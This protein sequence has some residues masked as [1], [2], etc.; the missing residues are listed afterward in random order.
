MSHYRR[1]AGLC[2]PVQ[3]T[4]TVRLILGVTLLRLASETV[5]QTA[6]IPPPIASPSVST[7]F[8]DKGNL[9]GLR[10]DDQLRIGKP[11]PDDQ[12]LTFTASDAI[13]GVVER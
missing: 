10:F 6:V 12:A 1:R 2:A 8:P 11:I 3:F 9:K 4:S 7:L 13:D 5:A